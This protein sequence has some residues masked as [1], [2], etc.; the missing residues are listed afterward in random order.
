MVNGSNRFAY[1][2]TRLKD[3]AKLIK[4]NAFQVEI[5]EVDLYGWDTHQGQ[6]TAT[7]NHPDLVEALSR[8]IKAFVD[9]LG[10]TYMNNVVI[11]VYSEFGRTAR[12]N[13]SLGTD[14]GN[15]TVAFAVGHPSRVA[16]RRVFHGPAGW[17]GLSDLRDG[18]D[19]KHSTDYRSLIFEA[20]ARHLGNSSPEIFPGFTPSPVGFV[21]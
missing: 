9:D 12:E 1:F 20:V 19:L 3:L 4:T 8:G 16:G 11:L 18:R 5:A 10:D 7:T 2:S 15:A 21:I 6:D 14:H 13:G 17:H